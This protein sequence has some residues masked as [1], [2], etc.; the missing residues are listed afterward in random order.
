[1]NSYPIELIWTGKKKTLK[2]YV[3]FIV[4][5][6]QKL[7]RNLGEGLKMNEFIVEIRRIWKIKQKQVWVDLGP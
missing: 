2:T 6:V 7:G 1:M 5:I 4:M 3:S